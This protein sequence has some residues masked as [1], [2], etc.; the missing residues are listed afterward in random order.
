[1]LIPH[2]L[3][4][5]VDFDG[6]FRYSW[7][8]GSSEWKIYLLGEV[9]LELM[10]DFHPDIGNFSFQNY[11]LYNRTYLLYSIH[12]LIFFRLMTYSLVG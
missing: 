7:T 11:L 10:P 9:P 3:H 2:M 6:D 4:H 5:V 8:K 12:D 1:M